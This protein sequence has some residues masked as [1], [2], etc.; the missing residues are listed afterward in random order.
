MFDEA[1]GLLLR[2]LEQNAVAYQVG[3]AEI[4]Q[5]GLSCTEKFSRA[6]QLKIQLREL[7]AVLRAHH[8]GKALL[9]LGR[10]FSAGHENAVGLCRSSAH[11]TA[12]L[13]KLR[14]AKALGVFDDHHAGVGD[15]DANFD[16]RG[17]DQDIDVAALEAPH[18]DLLF[19]G[20]ETAVQE[21]QA[22][23]AEMGGAQVLVHFRC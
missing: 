16:N 13:V 7:E 20:V 1:R 6:A 22:Q 2:Q 12:E 10:D 14:E 4:G 11:A 23:A 17:R 8:G 5:T 9:G 19:I 3:G 18:D 21:A 15:I